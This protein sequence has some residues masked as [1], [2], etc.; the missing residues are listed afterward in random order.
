LR[1]LRVRSFFSSSSF[2]LLITGDSAV[3][4]CTNLKR[5]VNQFRVIIYPLLNSSGNISN[6]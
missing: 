5:L 1:T 3:L 4:L 6:I 2:V